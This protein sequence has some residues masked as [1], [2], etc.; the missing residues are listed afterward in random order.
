M[1][2]IERETFVWWEEPTVPA[3]PTPAATQPKPR[4]NNAPKKPRATGNVGQTRYTRGGEA[5]GGRPA[6][7]R[8]S[9]GP[10]GGGVQYQPHP[11]SPEL[12]YESPD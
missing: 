9:M 6:V 11:Q 2:L 10:A 7:A 8:P 12:I 5:I 1:K 4:P 3:K